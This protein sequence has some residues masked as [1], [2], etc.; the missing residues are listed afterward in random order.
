MKYYLKVFL[1]SFVAFAVVIGG[2]IFAFSQFGIINTGEKASDAQGDSQKSSDNPQASDE[3]AAK[4][5]SGDRLNILVL[6]TDGGRSDT[7]MVFSYDPKN[8]LADIVSVPRDTYNHI[9]GKDGAAQRKIN[10]V[11]G[12]KGEEGGPQGLK[13]EISKILGVPISYYVE[14]DYDAVAKIVDTVGGVEV[15]IPFDLDYDDKYAKPELHIHLKEGTQTLDGQK[16]LQYLRWRKNNGGKHSMGDLERVKRQQAFVVKAIK[17]AVG[18]KLPFVIKDV[19]SYLKTDMNVGDMLYVGTQGLGFDFKKL[20]T[21]TIPGEADMKYG[22]S[23][24]IHD[25]D[26]TIEMMQEIYA[27]TPES[28]AQEEAAKTAALPGEPGT[29]SEATTGTTKQ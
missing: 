19:F 26:K 23:Y 17:Q 4:F 3:I 21:H 14:L 15:E 9:E 18:I 1:I 8:K 13:T 12:F 2:G 10:A 6:G 28:D 24:Y 29:Q 11:Y 16:A 7:L 27:R 5:K 20:K 22:A 25:P